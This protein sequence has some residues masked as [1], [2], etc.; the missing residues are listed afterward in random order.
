MPSKCSA[1]NCKSGYDSNKEK[2]DG[3]TFHRFPLENK[4]LL[5]LWLR[6]IS[7]VDFV[8]T[9]YSKLCSLHFKESD[10]LYNIV[11]RNKSRRK[12]YNQDRRKL[13]RLQPTAVPSIFE[14]LPS[15]FSSHSQHQERLSERPTTSR[16]IDKQQQRYY[17]LEEQ[18]MEEDNVASLVELSEKLDQQ[19]IPSGFL[20]SRCDTKLL[21]FYVDSQTSPPQLIGS[22]TVDHLLECH[23]HSGQRVVP[24][25]RYAHILKSKTVTKVS[26]IAN[27]MAFLKS[28]CDD[29]GSNRDFI[30][31]AVDSLKVITMLT[32]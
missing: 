7:R 28:F 26:Q 11:D 29:T 32:F 10:F 13:R 19:N 24:C 15:Y 6:R 8:P 2:Q 23:I 12:K 9:R 31:E 25:A 1:V 4:D 16:R 17:A 5:N 27:L 3:I 21:F 14:N 18:L 22:I 20:F 30:Q